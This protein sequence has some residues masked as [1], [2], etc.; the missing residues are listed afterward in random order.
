MIVIVIAVTVANLSFSIVLAE[1]LLNDDY[2][3]HLLTLSSSL[4]LSHLSSISLY[5]CVSTHNICVKYKSELNFKTSL[6]LKCA[7][8]Y[9]QTA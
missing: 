5:I 6:D 7:R 4:S 8:R 1:A 3:F 9:I 2:V